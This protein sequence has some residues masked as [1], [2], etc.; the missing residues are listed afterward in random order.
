MRGR[1]S[2]A[3]VRHPAAMV[4]VLTEGYRSFDP[5][6]R[7]RTALYDSLDRRRDA[8][9]ELVD[10]L[11]TAGPRSSLAHLSLVPAHWGG[12]GS[13]YAA[14]RRGEVDVERLR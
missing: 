2:A 12:W 3:W 6:A 14:L 4:P 1:R 13:T 9:F 5:R 7:F 8:L 10:T 11:L